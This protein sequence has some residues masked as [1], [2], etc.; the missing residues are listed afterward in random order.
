MTF[1]SDD[2]YNGWKDGTY[3]LDQ[4]CDKL[5]LKSSFTDEEIAD[6]SWRFKTYDDYFNSYDMDYYDESYTTKGGETVH[7][8]GKYG[9]DG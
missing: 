5:V 6:D 2:E 7:V 8:F 1:A 4:D 3:I 9:Y